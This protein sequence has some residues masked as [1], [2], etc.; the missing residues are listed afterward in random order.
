MRTDVKIWQRRMLLAS[1]PNRSWVL[2]QVENSRDYDA[3]TVNPV[4]NSMLE[5]SHQQSPEFFSI[6]RRRFG[7]HRCG[8]MPL[9]LPSQSARRA[10]STPPPSVPTPT[11]GRLRP[12]KKDYFHWRLRSGSRA[13]TSSAPRSG[14]PSN[15]KN[16]SRE[17]PQYWCLVLHL[18]PAALG[19]TTT[20]RS[21]STYPRV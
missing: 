5:P 4:E 19:Q 6:D 3:S 15:S 10:P 14:Q 1:L 9:E 16:A 7:I 12:A 13:K 17:S 8:V 18:R 20:R 21:A 2:A 11:T